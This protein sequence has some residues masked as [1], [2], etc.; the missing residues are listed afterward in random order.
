MYVLVDIRYV[1]DNYE[2]TGCATDFFRDLLR[3]F[4]RFFKFEATGYRTDFEHGATKISMTSGYIS[5]AFG[6]SFGP[7]THVPLNLTCKH[8]YSIMNQGTTSH[9]INVCLRETNVL[10]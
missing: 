3:P 7:M 5:V 6:S 4:L 1:I 2:K 10:V 8:C 9:N